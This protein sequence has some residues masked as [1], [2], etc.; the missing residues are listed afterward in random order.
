MPITFEYFLCF[1]YHMYNTAIYFTYTIDT[2]NLGLN[3]YLKIC[4]LRI[5]NIN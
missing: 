2:P 4:T 1:M 5:G 3:S